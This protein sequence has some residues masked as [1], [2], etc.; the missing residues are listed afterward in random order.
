[1]ES[2]WRPGMFNSK[3]GNLYWE[4]HWHADNEKNMIQTCTGNF[5]P[6]ERHRAYIYC[7]RRE[8]SMNKEHRS[9][10][11]DRKTKRTKRKETQKTIQSILSCLCFC[12]FLWPTASSICTTYV[13]P[14]FLPFLTPRIM[15]CHKTDNRPILNSKWIMSSYSCGLVIIP[16]K[17]L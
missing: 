12:T 1:M 13:A 3:D 15:T 6:K 17:K 4:K 5:C 10:K 11:N 16:V 9:M 14:L 8:R 2:E 7:T